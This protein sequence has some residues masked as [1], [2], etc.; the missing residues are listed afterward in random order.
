[1]N[2]KTVNLIKD[3]KLKPYFLNVLKENL[4]FKSKVREMQSSTTQRYTKSSELIFEH[5]AT[6][7]ILLEELKK[8]FPEDNLTKVMF[9]GCNY[10]LK[11][12]KE[13]N[14]TEDNLELNVL[15]NEINQSY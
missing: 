7:H 9:F 14:L 10:Y 6:I 15:I 1:M 5:H 3:E 11:I 4:I 12:I 2:T 13:G 8:Y